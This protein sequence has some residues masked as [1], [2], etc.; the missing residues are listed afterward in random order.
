VA[1]KRE[2]IER[3]TKAIQHLHGS[4]SVH[5][6]TEP[7]H[8]VFNGQTVWEGEVEVFSLTDESKATICYAWSYQDG[9][10]EHF[11]AVLNVPQV[12]TALDAVRA[13]IV[14]NAKNRKSN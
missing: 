12:K 2:Y 13:Y 14:G 1:N 9:T 6:N 4:G 5:I 7:V 8:E 3:L 10:R 11:V